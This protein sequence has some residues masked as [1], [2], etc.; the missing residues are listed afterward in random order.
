MK[1]FNAVT[2]EILDLLERRSL[3]D[4]RTGSKYFVI[5]DKNAGYLQWSGK[6]KNAMDA[7]KKLDADAGIAP[8]GEKLSDL[9]DSSYSVHEVS[10][11]EMDKI[12]DW[13]DRGGRGDIGVKLR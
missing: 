2:E 6:A 3:G 4:S 11:E 12:Q 1:D 13:W 7:M 5:F 9:I 10:K 8:N